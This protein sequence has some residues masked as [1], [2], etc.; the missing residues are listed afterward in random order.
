MLGKPVNVRGPLLKF[1]QSTPVH[2]SEPDR[3][4]SLLG[5]DKYIVADGEETIVLVLR[6]TM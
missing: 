2:E 5:G 1:R 4:A 6:R 3:D